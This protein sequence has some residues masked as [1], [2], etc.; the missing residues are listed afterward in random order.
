MAT[1]KREKNKCT[2]LLAEWN[3]SSSKTNLSK[4]NQHNTTQQQRLTNSEQNF[5]SHT[6]VFLS[7][8]MGSRT[9]YLCR[10][11]YTSVFDHVTFSSCGHTLFLVVVVV[12]FVVIHTENI[13]INT[14]LKSLPLLITICRTPFS[15]SP[16]REKIKHAH[17]TLSSKWMGAKFAL[18]NK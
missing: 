14:L 15:I 5:L 18:S 1:S 7:I 2:F 13:S 12:V 8:F 11:Q 3:L 9:L 17:N 10:I 6:R 16:S 4:N